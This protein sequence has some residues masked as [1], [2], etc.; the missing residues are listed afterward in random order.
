M[1]GLDEVV[2]VPTGRPWQKADSRV[3]DAEHRVQMTVLA[4]AADPRF[5]VSRVD[6]DRPGPTYT[7]DTLRDLVRQRPDADWHLIAG[8]DALSSIST[9]KDSEEVVRQ[10]TLVGITRPGYSLTTPLLVHGKPV[11]LVEMPSLDI[12]SRG[13]RERL[14]SGLPLRYL[15]PDDV[16]GYIAEAGLYA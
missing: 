12:S 3:S 2:F 9:W 4:T 1:V 6:A 5:S 14:R 8:A 10:A 11:I 13:C 16:A 15:V 7:I